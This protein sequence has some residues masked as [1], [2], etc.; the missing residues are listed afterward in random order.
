M[1]F[2]SIHQRFLER[3]KEITVAQIDK[4]QFSV[5]DLDREIGMSRSQVH[6]KLKALTNQ[7]VT[8]FIRDYRLQRAAE[9]LKQESGN[10]TEIAYQVG[11]STQTLFTSC[12][13]ELFGCTP[14]EYKSKALQN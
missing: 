5:E 14:S 10:I 4:H 1:K 13:Q 8:N 7:S 3:I 11:F 6:R 2:P 9:L 12:F